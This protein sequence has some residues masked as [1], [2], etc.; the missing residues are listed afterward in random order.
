MKPVD[1]EVMVS[2]VKPEKVKMDEDEKKVE[3]QL[4]S[5]DKKDV[6]KTMFGIDDEDVFM[7]MLLQIS[8]TRPQFTS[9]EAYANQALALLADIKPQD[10]QEGMLVSQM[11]A[12]HNLAMEMNRR[13]LISEQ[14]VEGVQ[15][16]INRSTKLM[17]TFTMQM[18]ALQRKRNKATQ[19]IQVQHVNIEAGGQAVVG[20]VAGGG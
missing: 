16:N 4:K 8:S 15:S 3:L 6:A 14:T 12:T 20:N 13:A 2:Q 18:E 19:V 10:A 7:Y 5:G 1:D 9:Q 17:R 11:I